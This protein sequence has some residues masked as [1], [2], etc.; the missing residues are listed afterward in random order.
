MI[1][2]KPEYGGG[3]VCYKK[4][5]GC[6]A[7]WTDEGWEKAHQPAPEAPA[8]VEPPPLPVPA[9]THAEMRAVLMGRIQGAEDKHN[10]TAQQRIELWKKYCGEASDETADVSALQ[11]LYAAL[12]KLSPRR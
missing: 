1:K 4:K 10:L 8:P 11:D 7:R 3:W 9:T 6:G 5:G 12:L 2:G